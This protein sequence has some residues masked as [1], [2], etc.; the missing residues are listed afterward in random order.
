MTTTHIKI[1]KLP[2]GVDTTP[3]EKALEA[4]PGVQSVTVDSDA[5]EAIV[6]HD[7]ADPGQLTEAVKRE[8][9]PAFV[10]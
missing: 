10:G 2:A 4:V 9:Y 8:G 3:L 6:E 1:A 5:H 7:A